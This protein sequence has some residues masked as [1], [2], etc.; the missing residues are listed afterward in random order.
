MGE[1]SCGL[2]TTLG[3]KEPWMNKLLNRLLPAVGT[4]I[5]ICAAHLAVA[6]SI[7]VIP[8]EDSTISEKD[9]FSPQGSGSTPITRC[10]LA[11][12]WTQRIG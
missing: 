8:V 4:G 6:E 10:W 7:T 5:W 2:D 12:I 9:M 3:S 1:G 11:V